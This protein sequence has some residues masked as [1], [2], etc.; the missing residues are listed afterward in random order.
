MIKVDGIVVVKAPGMTDLQINPK[1]LEYNKSKEITSKMQDVYIK[2][3]LCGEVY[4]EWFST[5]LKG[6]TTIYSKIHNE[7]NSVAYLSN[8]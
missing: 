7:S 5:F 4:D 3:I 6:K 2:L 8:G 1:D